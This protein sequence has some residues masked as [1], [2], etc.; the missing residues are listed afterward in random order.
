MPCS[1]Q[2]LSSSSEP[3]YAQIASQ[4]SAAIVAGRLDASL[5][6]PSIRGLA[7]D[8]GVSVITT[9]R[10][11]EELEKSGLIETRPGL[12]CFV[13]AQSPE[14]LKERRARMVEAGLGPLIDEAKRLGVA[15]EDF[16]AMVELLWKEE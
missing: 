9:K 3:I 13:A 5:P 7:A 16:D 10:A 2:I 8:L 1:I 4:I 14:M 11:Y 15:R 6:L 12:G